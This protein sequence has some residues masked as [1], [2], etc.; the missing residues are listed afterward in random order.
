M[1]DTS[2]AR[3]L[4]VFAVPDQKDGEPRKF[5]TKIGVA[6]TNRDGS[7]NLYLDSLP[8]GTNR[9][10]V[11]EVKPTADRAANGAGRA[12]DFETIEVGP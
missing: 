1:N 4:G 9:L 5:W 8:I 3:R 10:Q 11:R 2:A 6:F 7:I 12:G